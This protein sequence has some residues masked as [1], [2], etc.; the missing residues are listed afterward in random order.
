MDN[1]SFRV[2]LGEVCK[3]PQMYVGRE[4]FELAAAF[5]DG[6]DSA[7]SFLPPDVRHSGL[8]GFREWLAVRLN[9]CVRSPW[10]EIICREHTGLDQFESLQRLYEEFWHDRNERGLEAIG[11]D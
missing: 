1:Q 7:L 2:F 3:R 8:S 4:D 9:S 5:L 10:W 11:A 6:F